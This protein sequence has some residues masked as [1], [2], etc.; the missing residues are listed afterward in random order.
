MKGSAQR[1]L[2]K[3]ERALEHRLKQQRKREQRQSKKRERL[4]AHDRSRTPFRDFEPEQTWG[5]PD[6]FRKHVRF[7]GTREDY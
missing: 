6:D 2:L 1:E 7:G 3:R 4:A 5:T